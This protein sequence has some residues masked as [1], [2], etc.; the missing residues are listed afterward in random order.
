[1]AIH[2][3]FPAF[4]RLFSQ[5][6][7]GP[8]ISTIPTLSWNTSAAPAGRFIAWD[9]SDR[10]AADMITDFVDLILPFFTPDTEYQSA[11]IYT[12]AD[13]DAL[14]QPRAFVNFTGKVGSSADPAVPASMSTYSFRTTNFGLMKLVFLDA[15]V[16]TNFLPFTSLASSVPLTNLFNFMSD[17]ANA[18]SARD[19]GRPAQFIRAT[20]K[21]NDELRK[22]YRLD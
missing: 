18:I 21:I 14:P 13:I 12:M 20:F 1:M 6:E 16:T 2:S 15:P 19:N 4:F 17:E 11:T 22:S 10:D 5:S 7:F 8:H 3:L 9:G